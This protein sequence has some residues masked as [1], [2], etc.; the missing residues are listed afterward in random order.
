MDNPSITCK[1][2]FVYKNAIFMNVYKMVT[3]ELQCLKQAWDH[4]NL[5][6]QRVI[7]AIQV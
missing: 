7:L 4:E 3:A 1:M 5:F 6:Q 2:D